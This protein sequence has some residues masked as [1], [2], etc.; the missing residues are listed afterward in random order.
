[1]RHTKTAATDDSFSG[2]KHDGLKVTR[3]VVASGFPA[4]VYF[5]TKTKKYWYGKNVCSLVS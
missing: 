2:K 3:N 5:G 4:P 1:M